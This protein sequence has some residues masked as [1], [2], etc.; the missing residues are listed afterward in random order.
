MNILKQRALLQD[1]RWTTS[2][3]SDA[4][5]GWTLSYRPRR[6][7]SDHING[8]CR[9]T[10]A[11][12]VDLEVAFDR[13]KNGWPRLPWA[14]SCTAWMNEFVDSV[15][16]VE[17]TGRRG[18]GRCSSLF[19]EMF[20]AAAAASDYCRVEHTADCSHCGQTECK[21]TSLR[22]SSTRTRLGDRS[23]SVAGPCL[24]N[25]LPVALCDR[26]I[27]FVQSKSLWKTLWFV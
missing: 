4:R 20:T 13:K 25:S 19:E 1:E 8:L 22:S 14:V 7:W 16:I 3:D 9:R 10:L 17:T 11:E 12:A 5:N 26:D 27:S 2:E 21:K 15:G 24:W 18:A 23:F 6:R